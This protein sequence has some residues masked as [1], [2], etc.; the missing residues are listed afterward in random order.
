[1]KRI[2]KIIIAGTALMVAVVS[3]G[4][5]KEKVEAEKSGNDSVVVKVVVAEIQQRSFEDWGSYSADLRGIEDANLSAPFQG[6]R[7]NSI[8]AVGTVVKKGD[9]LCDIDGDKYEAA[10]QAAN[11]Q[12]EVAQGELERAKTNVANG[13]L[14][15][16]ALDGA[17]LAYQNARMLQAS[18]KRAYEDC[19][20]QAP[21]DGMLVSRSIDRYQTV[22]PGMTTVRLSK[23]D[24]LEALIAIPESEAFSYTEGMRTVFHLL[25][26]P[27]KLYSGRLENIDKVV[28]SRSRMVTARIVVNNVRGILKPGMVGRAKILR[29]SYSK[30]VVVPSVAL[31]RLQNG[32]AAMVVENGFARQRSLT[33]EAS[34]ADSSLVTKGLKAGDKLIVIGAFQVSEGTRVIY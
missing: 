10:L 11:A 28:D 3:S 23:M 27:G 33:V 32:I 7:V 26:D 13:S 21:F 1:M 20:C 25:Q 16:S 24:Q 29:K 19:Q 8:K 12:V 15:K 14:G 6:G 34:N 5:K 31:L 2:V 22:N 9:H 17:N 4:C 30:A 18:A